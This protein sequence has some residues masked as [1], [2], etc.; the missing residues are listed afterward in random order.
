MKISTINYIL[1]TAVLL[2]ASCS[3]RQ[4]GDA[5]TSASP[6]LAFDTVRATKAV[7]SFTPPHESAYYIIGILYA[8]GRPDDPTAY[9]PDEDPTYY[10]PNGTPGTIYDADT[11]NYEPITDKTLPAIVRQDIEDAVNEYNIYFAELDYSFAEIFCYT[12]PQNITFS[13]LIPATEYIFYAA[14]INP[15]T[16]DVIGDIQ[17]IRTIT[18]DISYSYNYF[19]IFFSGDTINIIP[20]NDDPY[21]WDY[22]QVAELDSAYFGNTR[23]YVYSVIELYENYGFIEYDVTTGPQQWVISRDDPSFLAEQPYCLVIAGYNGEISTPITTLNFTLTSGSL[24]Y[25]RQ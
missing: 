7:V 6:E 8:D 2:L 5:F 11:A 18:P 24:Q 22:T 23:E 16:Y 3:S 25:S 10:N 4:I 15:E 19:N 13:D 9:N 21:W 17:S 12:T 14:Q 20:G 1:L